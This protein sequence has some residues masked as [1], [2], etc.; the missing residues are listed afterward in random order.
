[1][2]GADSA[3]R[4][5]G[6]LRIVAVGALLCQ[7]R[8]R[9]LPSNGPCSTDP[10]PRMVI[11]FVALVTGFLFSV[12]VLTPTEVRAQSHDGWWAPVYGQDRSGPADRGPRGRHKARI[13]PGHLPPPGACRVWAPGRPPG[14]QSPPTSCRTAYRQ[15]RRS[16]ALVVHHSGAVRGRRPAR[17]HRRRAGDI[18]FRR[19]PERREGVYVSVEVIIDLLG[20]DGYRRLR[21]HQRRLDVRGRLA[22]RWVSVGSSGHAVLQ[23]R[24]GRHPLAELVDRNGDRRVESIFL[25]EG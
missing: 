16:G 8:T 4:R 7:G 6:C 10:V 15:A 24:A 17:W 5:G 19:R 25:R 12:F 22:V 1:M 23:V 14:H 21:T 13:P 20:R 18:V 2:L 9:L 3:P 11:R